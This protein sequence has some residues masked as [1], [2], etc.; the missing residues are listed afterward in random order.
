MKPQAQLYIIDID[1]TIA[2][3]WPTLLHPYIYPNEKVRHQSLAIFRG[4]RS[5]ILQQAKQPNTLI[6]YL[7]ARPPELMSTTLDWLKSCGLPTIQGGIILVPNAKSKIRFL[8]L[9]NA[10]QISITF[11][12]DLSYNHE[13]GD[14]RLYDG[15]IEVVKL[16]PIKYIGL[17]QLNE[18]QQLRHDY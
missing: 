12:D 1:N 14:I 2:D 7:S 9:A 5:W 4:M 3:T 13:N 15:V 10:Y 8:K 11:I 18:I 17:P 16:L 6:I